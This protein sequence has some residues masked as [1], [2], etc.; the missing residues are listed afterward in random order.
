MDHEAGPL[1]S[2]MTLRTHNRSDRGLG[3]PL[4]GGGVTLFRE[5]QGRP[6]LIGE[7]A[8]ED[9]AVEQKVEMNFPAPPSLNASLEVLERDDEPVGWRLVVRNAADHAVDYEA[10]LPNAE[11]GQYRFSERVRREDGRWIWHKRIP[12]NGIVSI[13]WGPP[14]PSKAAS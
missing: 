3:L 4:P 1:E 9:L 10:L 14:R 2:M 7:A 6:I 8:L 5:Y 12:A 13:E 11:E